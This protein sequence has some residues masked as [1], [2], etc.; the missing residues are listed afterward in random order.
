MGKGLQ[1]PKAHGITVLAAPSP[2]WTRR[3]FLTARRDMAA[4]A[5]R[6]ATAAGGSA[7]QRPSPPPPHKCLV[8]SFFK[9][10]LDL[11]STALEDRG[12]E[13]SRLHGSMPCAQPRKSLRAVKWRRLLPWSWSWLLHGLD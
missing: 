2:A 3:A 9:S 4:V 11:I 5:D 13:H 6:T 7:R 10:F 1:G 12:I 8:F